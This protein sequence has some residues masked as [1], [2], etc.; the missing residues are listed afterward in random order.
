[1]YSPFGPDPGWYENYWYGDRPQPRRRP[2]SA[3]FARFAVLVA[4]L[5]AGGAMLS[6]HH[7]YDDVSS[8]LQDWEQE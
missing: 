1:M 8:Q 6:K 3:S 7:A 2:F 5:A 4:L